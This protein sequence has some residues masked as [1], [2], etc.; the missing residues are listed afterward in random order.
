MFRIFE[1]GDFGQT[2]QI[3]VPYPRAVDDN[4]VAFFVFARLENSHVRLKSLQIVISKKSPPP[5]IRPGGRVRS[6]CRDAPVGLP[7]PPRVRA[8]T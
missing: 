6:Q 7:A 4:D 2:Q 8:V 5:E 3:L 1:S